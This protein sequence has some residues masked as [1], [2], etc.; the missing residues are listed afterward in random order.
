[1]AKTT[2][3]REGE[4]RLTHLRSQEVELDAVMAAG[5]ERLAAL[6]AGQLDDPRIHLHHAAVPEPPSVAKRR[7][8]GEA[9]AALS[10]GLLIAALAVIVWFRILPPPLAI[11]VLFAS[12][13]AIESF[14]DRNVVE[15]V[16]RITVILALIST[17]ILAV[18]YLR[19]L[20]LIA[21]LA[22]G[23]LLIS[24]NIGEIRRRL[25]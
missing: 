4:A 5:R 3:L 2:E 11:V 8:F 17:F 24:D 10:V 21:L 18:T 9:W 25:R 7:A 6:H 12:Y 23:L 20:L 16:L 13:L 15:L 14:F 19:E 22:L 1:V